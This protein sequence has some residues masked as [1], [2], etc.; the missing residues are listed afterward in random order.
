MT[1]L[2]APRDAA[3]RVGL[4]TSRLKQLEVEGKLQVLRDSGGRR[5]YDPQEIERYRLVR[6][7]MLR[8]RE[9]EECK[10]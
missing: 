9:L 1:T 2:L 6:E 7:E 3:R 10:G 4:S 8:A 5:L